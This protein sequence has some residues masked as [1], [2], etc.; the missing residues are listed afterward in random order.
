[1]AE[2]KTDRQL[3]REYAQEGSERAFA[4]LV[5]RHLDL[6]FGTALR[7]VKDERV[8]QE[9]AQNVFVMLARKAA[10]L[11]GEISLA[12]W[13]HKTAL[14]EVRQHWRGELRRRRREQTALELGTLMKD[15]D[16]L[17][18]A[19]AG[20]LDEGLLELRE[21][22]RH[23]LM[24]RYFEGRSHRE[25]GVLLGAR[26]DAV[27]MRIDKAL[28]RLTRFFRRRGYAVPAV[29]TTVSVLG[30]VAKAAPAGF[31]TVAAK[32]ALAAAGGGAAVG[33][34][35]LFLI[36]LMALTK[37][38][39]AILCVALAA[40][41]VAWEWHSNHVSRNEAASVQSRLTTLPQQ[42]GQVSAELDQLRAESVRLDGSWAD[43]EANRVRYEAAAQKLEAMKGRIRG[44]LTEGNY[45][46]P[47]DLPYVRV[48]KATI[49][50]LK[51]LDTAPGTFGSPG[52]I[53]EQA[54]ELLGIT[55]DEKVPA[56]QALR[57]YWNGVHD[58]MAANAYETNSAAAPAG[59]LTKT[60][61]VPPLG[62]PLKDLAEQ[63]RSQL[64]DVLGADREKL[65]FGGWD[66][67]AIQIF[68]PGNLWKISEEAQTFTGW[69]DPN[70]VGAAPRCGMGWHQGSSGI[71][72]DSQTADCF[73]FMPQE[74][75]D[76]FFAPWLSQNGI[77][78]SMTSLGGSNE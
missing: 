23:A 26:E 77:T 38:Q 76:R 5:G 12:G 49:K 63:T 31:A 74:I 57:S 71:S 21:S 52:K 47:G 30:A 15:D 9:V 22:D 20:E 41:P 54:Q 10:W 14:L 43:A 4:D 3:L 64:S 66:Q 7:G 37:T 32:S 55:A 11:G 2:L 44:L 59:R 40:A 61:I 29:A 18:K 60:V 34:F 16:S 45:R 73:G 53:S 33:G 28:T 56:E 69:I 8:A 62:Q 48:S 42:E 70:A 17:L 67:G 46:W 68:W 6:V 25:I 78:N 1:M 36:K 13:L 35:H 51:L 58:L 27:R 24:L 72:P 50:S 65:L 19:L 75:Q 39:T